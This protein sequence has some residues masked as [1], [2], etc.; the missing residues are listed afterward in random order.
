MRS[1]S[2]KNHLRALAECNRATVDFYYRQYIAGNMS[3]AE[4]KKAAG[5]VLLA[6]RIG[7]TGY[8]FVWDINKAPQSVILAVHP[9]IQGQD[10][11][12]IDFVQ[13][14]VKVKNGYLEYRWQNPDEEH[15][16][17]KAMYLAYFEP[18]QWIIAVSSYKQ[19][20]LD[21]MDVDDLRPAILSGAFGRTGYFYIIDGSGSVVIHPAY[22]GNVFSLADGEGRLFHPGN[23][24]KEKRKDRIFL[25]KPRRERFS[26]KAGILRLRPGVRLDR[27][28][29][30]YKDE[31]TAP[32][33]AVRF[34]IIATV[35]V[36][37]LLVLP[38]SFKLA[39]YIDAPLQKLVDAFKS[40]K[41]TNPT[42]RLSVSSKD[43]IGD[44]TFYFNTFM[45][46]LDRETAE[47]E[48]V[49]DELK[50]SQQRLLQIIEFLPDAILV[51]DKNAKVL[52]WN[53]AMEALTGVRAELM[54]GKGDYEY[55]LPFYGSR[56]PILIDLAL[57]PDQEMEK[58]YTLIQRRGD[59]VFG[60]AFTP[61]L[62]PG[63]AHLS[64]TATI[65][66]DSNGEV[67][68]AIE[69]IRAQHGAQKSGGKVAACGENGGAGHF[70]WW[71]GP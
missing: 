53:R 35:I 23:L 8:V 41:S 22:K 11:W 40:Q 65:L 43:E 54:I 52:A 69:S 58:L 34:S 71:S 14:G 21:L 19:E 64:A 66:R 47:R 5:S 18:W 10:V 28:C 45:D 56:R 44:L 31:F 68:A 12:N 9:K 13:E 7:R 3:E 63:N 17:E 38:I 33:Y 32:L 36:I 20:F 30:S 42:I 55:S 49:E 1:A 50:E 25:E 26:S 70:G 24:F 27:R 15:P 4:A 57:H 6:Q 2:I 67:I 16:R 46:T 37:V 61:N 59:I 39:Y 29:S 48:R 60:E 62:P 51:T